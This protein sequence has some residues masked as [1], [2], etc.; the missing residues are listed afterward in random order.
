MVDEH[1]ILLVEDDEA[2]RTAMALALELQGYTVTAVANGQEALD[3]LRAAGR[4]CLILL[5]LMM[6]VMD[7]WQFRRA[8]AQDPALAGIPVVVVSAD[9]SVPQ[10]A[11][12]LGAAGFLQ[13]PVE[14]DDL[15]VTVQRHC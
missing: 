1:L 11:A 12:A 5:D 2:T 4:P 15:L 10:K 8:Q 6:P 9:G 7:G 14:V 13:K 3:Q